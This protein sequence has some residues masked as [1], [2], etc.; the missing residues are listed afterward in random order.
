MIDTLKDI[1][2]EKIVLLDLIIV[3]LASFAVLVPPSEPVGTLKINEN[4]LTAPIDDIIENYVYFPEG[5]DVERVGESNYSVTIYRNSS[6]VE[7]E[8]LKSIGDFAELQGNFTYGN[9]MSRCYIRARSE[10]VMIKYLKERLG[11]EPEIISAPE[12]DTY[13]LSFADLYTPREVNIQ[14]MDNLGEVQNYKNERIMRWQLG[15]DLQ[16]GS[17]IQLEIKS[18]LVEIETD[19]YGKMISTQIDSQLDANTTLSRQPTIKGDSDNQNVIVILDCETDLD[20]DELKREIEEILYWADYIE[21]E[22]EQGNLKTIEVHGYANKYISSYLATALDSEILVL[23][24]YENRFS[25]EIHSHIYETKGAGYIKLTPILENIDAEILDSPK[26]GISDHTWDKLK[27]TI[28]QR[29]NSYGLKD[30]KIREWRV[31]DK[32][33]YVLIDLAGVYDPESALDILRTGRFEAKIGNTLVFTGDDIEEVDPNGVSKIDDVWG[34]SFTITQDAAENLREIAIAEG[35]LDVDTNKTLTMYLNGKIVFDAGFS[36]SLKSQIKS[37]PITTFRASTGTGDDGKKKAE[38]VW[39]ALE[40]DLPVE[41]T[42]LGSGHVSP[43]L[44]EA[45]IS[46]FRNALIAAFIAVGFIIY[47]RYR[48]P[49]VALAMLFTTFSEVM[50][51]FGFAIITSWELDLAAF[52]GII[53]AIGTGV[54][55]QIMITDETLRGEHKKVT[56]F[57]MLARIKQALGVIVIAALTTIVAMIPLFFLGFGALKGFAFTTIVGVLFGIT[58]TRPAYSS[59]VRHILTK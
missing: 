9:N 46:Q 32:V 19:S 11:A 28:E 20:D 35:A 59:I 42:V 25:L 38:E 17:W 5:V 21:V 55:H 31:D 53:A 39:I 54:D 47:L 1:L 4:N 13:K 50:L 34:V 26:A 37:S 40:Y 3:L 24:E 27:L 7:K 6:D 30:R 23:G 48:K 57:T 49:S 29:S 18:T 12:E 56:V 51:I 44:G 14:E 16:G 36:E 10:T 22:T 15:L 52:A 33:R 45:F 43:S 2:R 8:I 41:V 58:L